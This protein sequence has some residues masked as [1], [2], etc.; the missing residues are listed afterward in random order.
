MFPYLEF[1]TESFYL[2]LLQYVKN[3]SSTES[4][5]Y[6]G[7]ANM[8]LWNQIFNMIRSCQLQSYTILQCIY[9]NLPYCQF[10][11]DAINSLCVYNLQD[12]NS[13]SFGVIACWGNFTLKRFFVNNTRMNQQNPWFK[14]NVWTDKEEH[15]KLL[16][17]QC[18]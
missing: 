13:P 17:K 2:P 4:C 6:T 14:W 1:C 9:S 18:L 10:Q 16:A 3:M 15:D 8:L 7:I 11:G 5:Y 12:W